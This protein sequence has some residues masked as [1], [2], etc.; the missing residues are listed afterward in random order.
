MLKRCSVLEA[1]NV[2]VGGMISA[3][4]LVVLTGRGGGQGNPPETMT[5]K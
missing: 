3:E 5:F 2:C 1:D 4:T